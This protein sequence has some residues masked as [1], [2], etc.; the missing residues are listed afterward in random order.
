M[1][2]TAST[3]NIA[4]G[5]D[6]R[7]VGQRLVNQWLANIHTAPERGQP[8]AYIFVMGNAVEILRAFGFELVFPEINSLQTGV[9]KAAPDLLAKHP[10]PQCR[11]GGFH[12]A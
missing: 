6:A 9:R 7:A 4:S 10:G 12:R 5:G 1:T 11:A 8:V 3:V 2:A